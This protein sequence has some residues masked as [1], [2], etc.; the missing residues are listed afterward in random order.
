[1]DVHE[2]LLEYPIYYA[3]GREGWAVSDKD[4]INSP[5]KKGVSCILDAIVEHIPPPTQKIE[6]D[7]E[8]LIS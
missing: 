7:F 4:L 6:G 3:S 5:D 8:L 1:M 2:D